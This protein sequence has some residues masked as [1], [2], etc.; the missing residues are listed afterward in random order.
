MKKLRQFEIDA[1]CD[2]AYKLIKEKKEKQMQI[3]FDEFEGKESLLELVDKLIEKN[4]Q[5][6]QLE[7]EKEELSNKINQSKDILKQK[8]MY[9][10]V[11]HNNTITYDISVVNMSYI[12]SDIHREIILQGIDDSSSVKDFIKEL[13]DKFKD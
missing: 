8:G 7:E 9:F 11:V 2:E 6:K 10:N 4:Q 1:I 13:V 5:I 12:R 3:V